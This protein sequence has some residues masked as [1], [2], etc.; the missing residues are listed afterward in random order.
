MKNHISRPGRA[1]VLAVLM[2][3]FVECSSREPEIDAASVERVI[4]TLSADEMLGRATFTPSIDM[5][6]DF[7]RQEFISIG[8]ETFGE[9]EDYMQRF[10][11][12]SLQIRSRRVMLNGIEIPNE[13]T[14]A[15]ANAPSVHW[16]THDSIE[17][18]VIGPEED[19]RNRIRSIYMSGR[20]TLLLL[21]T[22]HQAFFRRWADQLSDAP[23]AYYLDPPSGSTLVCVLTDEVS[24]TSFQVDVL[25]SVQQ[26][27]LTNVVGIIPG[28]RD[29][30]IVLF[31][32]SY[33]GPGIRDPVDGDSIVNGANDGAAGTTTMIE[34]AR[35]FKAMGKPERTLV[36]AAL[37]GEHVTHLGARYFSRQLDPER[38]VAML[39]MGPIGKIDPRGGPNTAFV[40]GFD[41]SDVGVILQHA[42]EGTPYSFYP[43][44]YVDQYLFRR[45]T[46]GPFACLGVPAHAIGTG[47]TR[48]EDFH[49]PSDEVETLDLDNMTSVIQA[50]A[51]AANVIISGEATPTRI[52][53]PLRD[54]PCER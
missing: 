48:D 35:H 38:I 11:G 29:D 36:F 9:L 4:T 10:M 17:V 51:L 32:A 42:V 52:D 24:A 28:R 25:G 22:S 1:L 53:P 13:R 50:I 18:V 49:R 26:L 8:L 27:P 14:A 46:N 15:D 43:D 16:V 5:A 33:D 54:F 3:C 37:T 40:T 2:L 7:I 19:V 34:L 41:R 47:S 20:N 12:Y 44:P 45:S 31:G 21:N 23:P 6:A 30:E 39:S